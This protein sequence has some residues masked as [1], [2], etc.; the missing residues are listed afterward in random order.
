M[1]LHISTPKTE[2]A[3]LLCCTFGDNSLFQKLQ[4]ELLW[5]HAANNGLPGWEQLSAGTDSNGG[6]STHFHQINMTVAM[7]FASMIANYSDYRIH[8]FCAT[9]P[10]YR[11]ASQ[12]ECY[13]DQQVHEPRTSTV[14]PQPC[15]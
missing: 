5:G 15:M 1:Y 9:T 6:A 10:R 13:G 14:R 12:L 11:H 7:K 8:Q 4:V 3:R 2:A